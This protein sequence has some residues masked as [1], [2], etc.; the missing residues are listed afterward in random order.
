M[1][2]KHRLRTLLCCVGLEVGALMGVPMRPEDIQNLIRSLNK[3][4]VAHTNPDKSV[5]G[6]QPEAGKRPASINE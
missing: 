4:K 3:P 5:E 1:A 2:L 6:D